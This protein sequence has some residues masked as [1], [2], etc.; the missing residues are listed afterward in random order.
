MTTPPPPIQT[1]TDTNT[2]TQEMNIFSSHS[3]E[4]NSED[5]DIRNRPNIWNWRRYTG[6]FTTCEHYSR[7]WFSRSLWSKKFI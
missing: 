3:T 6:C 5:E 1:H 4:L 2:I 7:R